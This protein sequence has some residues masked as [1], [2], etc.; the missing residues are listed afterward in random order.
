M[1]SKELSKNGSLLH[2]STRLHYPLNMFN[3]LAAEFIYLATCAECSGSMNRPTA[4]QGMDFVKT[5][6]MMKLQYFCILCI[7]DDFLIF[8]WWFFVWKAYQTMSPCRTSK[9]VSQQ[10]L[11]SIINKNHKMLTKRPP[12][13]TVPS[14]T[15]RHHWGSQRV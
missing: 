4:V 8:W 1:S 12:V 5:M 15:Q 6:K 14:G 11:A 9:L 3:P 2:E 13:A 7:F 10:S